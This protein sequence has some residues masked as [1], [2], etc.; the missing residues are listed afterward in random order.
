MKFIELVAALTS[1]AIIWP[2]AIAQCGPQWISR[3]GTNGVFGSVNAVH[4]W[5]PDGSGP[6]TSR[7]ILGGNFSVAGDQPANG[8]AAWDGANWNRMGNGLAYTSGFI[9]GANGELI[10]YTNNSSSLPGAIQGLAKWNGTQWVQFATKLGGLARVYSGVSVPNGKYVIGGNFITTDG[11]NIANLAMWNGE[12]WTAMGG[13]PAGRVYS[14]KVMSNGDILAAGDFNQIGSVMT[15]PVARWDGLQWRAVGSG[16]V[17]SSGICIARSSTDDIYLGATTFGGHQVFKLNQATW[18]PLGG[19]FSGSIKTLEVSSDGVLYAAGSFTK[20]GGV[21]ANSIARWVG[22]WQSPA[23]VPAKY[24]GDINCIYPEA[25]GSIIVGGYFSAISEIS[26]SSIAHLQSDVWSNIA[27]GFAGGVNCSVATADGRVV[28]G[29]TFT[30]INGVPFGRIAMWDGLQWSAMGAGFDGSVSQVAV[31]S[32]GDILAAGEMLRGASG[33]QTQIRKWDGSSWVP[34]SQHW[35]PSGVRQMVP[36]KNGNIAISFSSYSG[37]YLING[38]VAIFDGTKWNGLG[39]QPASAPS[40]MAELENGDLVVAGQFSTGGTQLPRVLRWDG[41]SWSEVGTGTAS[42]YGVGSVVPLKGDE[43]AIVVHGLD[44]FS[45][46][47]YCWSNSSWKPI[48]G[49]ST[50]NYKLTPMSGGRLLA[51]GDFSSINGVQARSLATWNGTVWSA[52]GTAASSLAVTAAAIVSDHEIVAFGG[53]AANNWSGI[54]L[55]R[56]VDSLTPIV[57]ASPKQTTVIRNE[58]LVLTA[59]ATCGFAELPDGLAADWFRNG[60]TISNGEG[61]ASIEG[62]TVSGA[63]ETLTRSGPSV[64]TISGV[65]PSDRGFY[66]IRFRNSCGEAT[67]VPVEVKVKAHIADINADGRVD[68]AD[69]ILFSAQY[70]LMLCAD[71]L[72]PD[73][74]SADFNHDGFVDDADFTIFAPAYNAMLLN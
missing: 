70:D 56:R 57:A 72:M 54:G 15:G 74:C 10:A 73:S 58:T 36:M 50:V 69:F 14:L 39:S 13:N 31:D 46:T 33:L 20:I 44:S 49:A 64:L 28:A 48:G 41:S 34:I 52:M 66:S 22:V 8:I 7:L 67:S 18:E 9:T 29:G 45:G 43:F 55:A 68:D 35:F 61:G 3:V 6:L 32:H 26:A 12:E 21:T 42:W 53:V 2:Q 16:S 47:V 38:W 60:D 19:V 71:P 37:P 65:K 40:G 59:A 24:V 63:S 1:A 30:S 62:G 27:T 25:D 23:K 11:K 4:S 5:D 51:Y 17:V